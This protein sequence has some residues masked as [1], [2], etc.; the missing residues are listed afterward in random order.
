MTTPPDILAKPTVIKILVDQGSEGLRLDKFLASK[1]SDL[2]RTRLQDLIERGLVELA[3]SQ[4][5]KP[6]KRLSTG[7]RIRVSVPPPEPLDLVPEEIPLDLVFEDQHLIVI[8]KK[9]GMVVHP[10]AGNRT[11]T[12]VHALLARCTDLSGIAGKLRP[13][14][15]HRLDKDTSGLMIAAKTDEAHRVL[16]DMFKGR[17]IKKKYTAVISGRMR[18]SSGIIDLPIGRHPRRRTVMRVDY[19]RGRPAITGFKKLR[20]LGGNYQLIDLRLHTGRT[21]QIRVHMSHVGHPLVGDRT[22]GGPELLEAR[23]GK[24]MVVQ[25]QMLHSRYLEFEHP[26]TGR[27]LCLEI[28]VPED[29]KEVIDFLTSSRCILD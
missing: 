9:A 26:V 14:I 3:D 12:I 13:G 19:R 25:R 18:D 22:Y 2:S 15:V 21:H 10:G 8:N 6:G 16:V 1:I 29:M 20:D 11:G 5:L 4:P 28:P 7:D 23:D 27:Q 17:R 24:K